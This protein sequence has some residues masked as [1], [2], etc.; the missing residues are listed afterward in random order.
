MDSARR[1][2][3][4]F[5]GNSNGNTGIARGKI[6]SGDLPALVI[7][8]TLVARKV[9]EAGWN[10]VD[11]RISATEGST[12]ML[13]GSEERRARIVE[14]IKH[15]GA[16]RPTDAEIAWAREVAIHRFGQLQ[17]DLQALTWE[18]DPQ[19]SFQNLETVSA[20][21]VSDVARIYF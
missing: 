8:Q 19:G 18:R 13:S 6:A 17:A 10:D 16:E 7:L 1:L 14:W 20:G 9:I 5:R 12:L 21:H 11:V 3:S 4:A 15:L 2:W